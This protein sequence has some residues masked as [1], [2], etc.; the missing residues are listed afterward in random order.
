MTEPI[1]TRDKTRRTM[2]ING[3][4]CD[5]LESVTMDYG[6]KLGVTHCYMLAPEPCSPEQDAR[7]RAQFQAVL[8]GM[9]LKLKEG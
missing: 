6:P 1:I 9:G 8:A 2:E 3:K 7:D 4:M 5:V